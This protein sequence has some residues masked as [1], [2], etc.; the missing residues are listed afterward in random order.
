MLERLRNAI[1]STLIFSRQERLLLYALLRAQISAGIPPASACATL[2]TLTGLSPTVRKAAKAGAQAGREGRA[3]F[4]GMADTNLFPAADIGVL[5]I[6]EAQGYIAD[7]LTV[8]ENRNTEPLGFFVKVI[9]PNVYYIVILTVLIFLS[10]EAHDHFSRIS[11]V[12]LA[13]N[14][15]MILSQTLHKWMPG[16]GAGLLLLTAVTWY[17]KM[18]WTGRLRK[19]LIFFDLEARYRIGIEFTALAEML[20]RYGAAHTDILTAAGQVMTHNRYAGHH[21]SRAMRTIKTE[22]ASWQSAL[23]GGLLTKEH[24]GLL[25]GLVPGG[26]RNL[27]ADAYKAVGMIQRQLLMARYRT[28]TSAVRLALLMT[29]MYL[30][31]TLAEGL[32]SMFDSI[33]TI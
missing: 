5:S 32:Y 28:A 21:I 18:H 22:G 12:D 33:R 29:I 8:I 30:F 13:T 11:F 2:N 25:E 4:A 27:Y 26:S 14:P 7:A 3:V 6:A 16:T 23:S 15:A 17:G 1:N 19:V 9:I 24:A 31:V 10:W 20:S